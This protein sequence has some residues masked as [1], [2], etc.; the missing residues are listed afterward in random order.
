MKIFGLEY[1]PYLG[2]ARDAIVAK[3]RE[4]AASYLRLFIAILKRGHQLYEEGDDRLRATF[5]P[6]PD[7]LSKEHIKFIAT[8]CSKDGTLMAET[9][10]KKEALFQ[11]YLNR[12]MVTA[13]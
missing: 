8:A 9:D 3:D 10:E 2:K 5:D 6:L 7:D 12:F 1:L 11:Q 13:R 4:Q